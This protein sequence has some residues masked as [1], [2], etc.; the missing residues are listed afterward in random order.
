MNEEAEELLQYAEKVG[1]LV[2]K[3]KDMAILLP[4][5]SLIVF[6]AYHQDLKERK[7]NGEITPTEYDSRLAA[8][9]RISTLVV[10]TYLLTITESQFAEL[11]LLA[12]MG[13][14]TIWPTGVD[15]QDI[16]NLSWPL[17]GAA[18][19]VVNQII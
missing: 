15:A 11:S 13:V 18:G 12:S 9:R 17:F 3:Y 2:Q 7:K 16:A 4:A 19:W 5:A 1:T 14:A 6:E 8:A 10:G